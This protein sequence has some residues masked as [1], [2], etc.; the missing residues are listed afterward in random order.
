MEK[1]INNCVINVS[2]VNGSGSQTANS[3]MLKTIFKMGVPVAGKNVFPSNIAGLPTWFWI[4]A[5]EQSYL[6]RREKADIVVSLNPSTWKDDQHTLNS[7]GIFILSSDFKVAPGDL[8]SDIQ[9]ITVPFR[10]LVDT[11][12]D[13]IKVKKILM[14]MI[15]VGVIAYLVDLDVEKFREALTQQLGS[16]KNLLEINFAAFKAGLDFM[17]QNFS[18]FASHLKIQSSQKTNGKI[19]IDGNSAAALGSVVGGCT[20]VSWYPITPSTSLVEHFSKFVEEM[21]PKD[22]NGQ[23]RFAIVQAEDELAAVG[24]IMGAGW[25]GARAMTATS[26]PGLSLMNETLGYGYFSEIPFVLWDVQRVG[27]STGMP[28]RTQQGDLLLAHLASH[29]DTLHPVLLPG[30]AEECFEFAQTAFDVAERLQTPVVVLSDLDLGMNLWMENEFSLTKKP[31]D[32]GKVLSAAELDAAIDYER[33]GDP[34]GDGIPY[35]SFAGTKSDKGAYLTRGSGH[36][37]KAAY[38]EKGPEYQFIV[39]RLKKK[40]KT[41]EQFVPAPVSKKQNS[42]VGVVLYGSSSAMVD[43]VDEILSAKIG[44]VDWMRIRALPFTTEVKNFIQTHDQVLVVDQNRDGQMHQL[45][46]RE[47]P[48]QFSKMKS[49]CH[50][51]GTSMTADFLSA[52]ILTALDKSNGGKI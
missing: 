9:L 18:D 49:I 19:L 29:G 14:N 43:E 42:K 13:S 46:Q 5:N 21:R 11:V 45:L 20:F 33:Y 39:D 27:P 10:T 6:G 7:G 15:Y 8:R 4:R 34:D 48:E 2:T 17:T 41:A 25:A 30:T 47:Y 52:A 24:M 1:I 37:R 38:T 51:D 40:W 12:T 22:N 44:K 28:T 3:V 50:Y 36:N 32:R 23:N 35:R 16:K 26:G 31:Y